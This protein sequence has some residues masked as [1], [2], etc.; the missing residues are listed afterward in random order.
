[1][2]DDKLW[3]LKADG[4]ITEVSELTGFCLLDVEYGSPQPTTTY[5]NFQGSDGNLDMGTTFGTRTITARFLIT[6]TDY[7][8]Y[9]LLQ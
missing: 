1:M 8:D 3:L 6:A 2:I 9:Y 4:S 7:Q 5:T